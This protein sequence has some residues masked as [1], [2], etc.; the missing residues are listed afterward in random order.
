MKI[1]LV[2]FWNISIHAP[3]TGSDFQQ[4]ANLT[5]I[6]QFQSTL[7]ARGAT[8]VSDVIRLSITISIH[9]P[10]TGSD[11]VLQSRFADHASFQSTL[12]ARGATSEVVSTPVQDAFQSTLPARGATAISLLNN[13]LSD[14]SIHAPRT[15]SDQFHFMFNHIFKYFNPRSPHGERPMASSASRS[16][17]L[18]QS[19]LPARGAT[20]SYSL[21]AIPLSISI[22]APRTGSDEGVENGG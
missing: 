14:I 9:A 16:S 3:R 4:I 19:T 22:H 18:F 6:V 11:R 15:G 20:Y 21:P 5:G 13:V 17:G 7:P 10:R 8:L 1:L 2:E 12:P